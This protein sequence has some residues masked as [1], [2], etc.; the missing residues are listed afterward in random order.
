[1]RTVF[2]IYSRSRAKPPL[3]QRSRQRGRLA[4]PSAT[5]RLVPMDA[6]AVGRWQSEQP[7]EN[8]KRLMGSYDGWSLNQ[9]GV[10]TP[11]DYLAEFESLRGT[12]FDIVTFSMARGSSTMYPSKVGEM[13]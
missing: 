10:T 12:D 5:V 4:G 7:T 9:W 11:E 6:G 8:T 3:H 1:M 13:M 2:S